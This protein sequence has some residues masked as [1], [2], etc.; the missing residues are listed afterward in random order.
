MAYPYKKQLIILFNTADDWKLGNK[1]NIDSP[2]NK[3]QNLF[4][5][6]KLNQLFISDENA[7]Y[8]Y[9]FDIDDGLWNYV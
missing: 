4:F 1:N 5:I 2:V 6:K 9:S 3:I 8:I 7:T